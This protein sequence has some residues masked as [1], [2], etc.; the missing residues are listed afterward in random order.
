MNNQQ[1]S[2]AAVLTAWQILAS[3]GESLMIVDRDYRVI[4]FKEPLMEAYKPGVNPVGQ[5]CYRVF[6]DRDTPCSS[7]CPVRPMFADGRPH[8]VERHFVT[9]AGEEVWRE[10]RAYPIVDR[11]GVVAFAARISFD[12]THRK[13]RQSRLEGELMTLE[14]S[15]E[16]MN[17][18]QL[19]ELPFQPA[20]GSPL[21]KRELEVLRLTAQG[22]SKPRI[23]HVLGISQN[24]VKR[25]VVNIFNKLGV[26]DRAQAAVWAAR[27]GLV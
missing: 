12:I 25:H 1:K 2:P 21:T 23:A 7:A 13:K 16:E 9:T 10:A 27:Q 14:R 22:L 19:D 11:R 15:L 4:W 20:G 26:N 18:F 17:R 3:L 8:S 5:P 24:T 6:A